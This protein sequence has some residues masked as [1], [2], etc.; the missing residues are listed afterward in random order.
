M[1]ALHF[2]FINLHREEPQNSD[3]EDRIQQWIAY[4]ERRRG[5]IWENLAVAIRD[6]CRQSP[7]HEHGMIIVRM[8]MDA[9]RR[10]TEVWVVFVAPIRPYFYFVYF[11]DIGIYW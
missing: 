4:Y 3:E 11:I 8:H 6:S 7:S 10:E 2:S 5:E 1:L 9:S